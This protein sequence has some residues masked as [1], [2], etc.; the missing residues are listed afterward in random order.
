MTRFAVERLTVLATAP[1]SILVG[2]LGFEPRINTAFETAAFAIWLM[3]HN[4][5]TPTST[6][7][8]WG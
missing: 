8:W 1:H 2:H 4:V 5:K 7:I 6:A 3:A